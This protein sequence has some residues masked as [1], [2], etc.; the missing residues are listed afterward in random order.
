MTTVGAFEAK[1]HFSE[2]LRKVEQGEAF[3]IQRRGK[4]VA[5]LTSSVGQADAGALQEVLAYFRNMRGQ[6][7]A[8]EISD[9]REEGRR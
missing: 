9:W 5:T 3:E 8:Q 2:L 1:T 6:V 7:S 4:P